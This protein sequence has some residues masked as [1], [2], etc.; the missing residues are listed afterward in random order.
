MMRLKHLAACVGMVLAAVTSVG[1][2]VRPASAAATLS[3]PTPG[4]HGAEVTAATHHDTSPPLRQ[5]VAENQDRNGH[6]GGQTAAPA[7]CCTAAP[8]RRGSGGHS[9]S[10]HAVAADTSARTATVRVPST[11]SNFNGTSANGYAPPDND[12]AAGPTQYVELV[13]VQ[14]AVYSKTGALILG[15]QPTNTLWSGF[16]NDCA[17]HNDGDG[18]I[19]FDTMAQRWIIQQ[20]TIDTTNNVYND[21]VAVSTSSDATGTWNRYSF[22]YAS[23]PDYPKTG[24]WPDA[25]YASFNLFDSS[26]TTGLGTE[27]CAFDRSSML[28]GAA[29]TQQCFMATNSGEHTLLPAT[30]DGTRQPPAGAAEWFVGLSPNG[31]N[32]LGYYRFHVDWTTPG[33]STLSTESDLPVQAFSQACGGGTC[34]PQSGTSQRL[35][36]LGDRVMFRL[37]YRNFGDHEA[38][39]VNHSITAGSSVGVRWY[40]LRPNAGDTALSVF[41]Q[42]TYAPDSNYRWMGSMAMDQSGD[43][44]L[45]YSISSSA[46]KPG[47]RYT[48]RLAADPAGTMPQGEATIITGAGNQRNGLTRWGDYTEMSVDPSDDCTFWYVNQYQPSNGSFNW[49]TRIASFKFPGC[50]AAATPDFTIAASPSSQTVVQ[51][52]STS[53]TV[54][55]TAVNGF[56]GTVNLGASGFGAGASGSYN[57]ASITGSGTSTLTVST[58]NAAATGSFPITITGTSGTLS[59]ST[60]V[61]LVVNP[62]P[63]FSIAASPGSQT[64]VQGS[65]TTYNVTVSPLNGFTGT[66]TLSATGFGTGATPSFSPTSVTGGGTSTLT[67]T[68]TTSAATG[69]FPI[70]ITGTSGSLNHSANV[71]LVVNPPSPDFTVAASPS[72]QTVIQS[73]STSYTVTVTALY[74][75]SGTVNLSAT[76]FG[77][78]A[79]PSFN[80]TSVTGGGPSTL[81]VTTTSSAATGS[82][83]ITITGTSGSLTHSAGVTLVVNPPPDFTIAASPNSQTVVQG[84]GTTYNVTVTALNGFT[85]TVN[86]SVSGFGT[87][88]SGTFNPTSVT[89]S[90]TSTLTVTTTGSAATGTFPITITG[91]S[92]ALSHATGVN[93]VVNPPG[94]VNGGF[95]TGNFTGWTTSGQLETIVS[96]GHTGNYAAQLGGT[97]PT[98]GD[99]TMQQTV[100]VPAAGGTLSLWY[101]PHCPDTITYDQ[102]QVQIRNTSNNVLA[103]LLNTCSN[104]GTWTQL[105]QDLSAWKGT[106]VVLWFNSHDDNYPSDPTY[107][108][109]DDVA[110]TAPQ[111]PPP[112]VVANGGFE[113]G[114][115][116]GWTTG[117][118]SETVVAS[119]HSGSYAA[120]LGS[121]SPTNGD[122][123]MQQTINVPTGSPALSF[124]YQPHCPDTL[125]YDQQ[126][127]QIR[128]TSNAVLATVLNV[129]SNSGAWT[130]VTFSMSAYAGTSVVLWFNSHDDNYPSDPTYTLFDD[131]NVH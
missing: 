35:D 29:A 117:G 103:T 109:F 55:V 98:N 17:T 71:T 67:V 49:R 118:Q 57:P 23:F 79:T 123:T 108:L 70:T 7:A 54:T 82:F 101:Q 32:A 1:L 115:Y 65:S 113:T 51:S 99:S 48:G 106:T 2:G 10:S 11:N 62:P 43:M 37:A 68:T 114:N 119:G 66:V 120:R 84:N 60:Q 100:P 22:S 25:Y 122:S 40:E 20:F 125:T 81:T 124:W 89:G 121:T 50:G 14:L 28:A 30:L 83:P 19:L 56:A 97:S 6:P 52:N 46:I 94:I 90:G 80:P 131:I 61:T 39:V 21:C 27:V 93:L 92:G 74:G 33:N 53:Y 78:G 45:G 111:P 91:T 34:I 110:I 18:T 58:T 102:E 12:G 15:P 104:T 4:S 96:P 88:A 8:V 42:G 105:T 9:D 116:S 87:G 31:G 38:L 5:L 76:G 59:H 129:C 86:L 73:N 13:N 26:G 36:S 47:I 44:A 128:S 85:G 64:V 107:T 24:V 16:G 77:A 41:Q 72:S 69:S 3:R 126:Q 95:E 127:M 75:F 63:D 130:Q 112:N